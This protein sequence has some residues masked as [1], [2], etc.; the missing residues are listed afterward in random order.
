[1]KRFLLPA[2]ILVTGIA[3]AITLLQP[4]EP[5]PLTPLNFPVGNPYDKEW[6]Q[7]DSLTNLGLP[8][9]ALEI[10]E[11]IYAKALKEKNDAQIIKAL[12]YKTGSVYS[13]E[14]DAQIKSVVELENELSNIKYPAQPVLQSIIASVYWRY[15]QT[16]RWQIQNRTE[17]SGFVPDDVRTW[18]A[19]KFVNKTA[20]LYFESLQNADSLKRT[21]LGIFDSILVK[22]EASKNFRPTLYDFLAHRALEFFMNSESGLTKP[23]YQFTIQDAAYFADAEKFAAMKIESKDSISFE[24][25]ALKLLQDLLAFHLSQ[26]NTLP[27][28]DNDLTRLRFAHQHSVNEL[29]DSLYLAALKSLEAKHQADT[30]SARVGY[31]IA[32]QLFEQ[33]GKYNYESAKQYRWLKKA[34]YEKCEEVIKRHPNTIGANNCDALKEQ[35]LQKSLNLTVEE[36][37]IP[38]SPF[39]GLLHYQNLKEVWMRAV[40]LTIEEQ[41]NFE[42]IEWENRVEFLTGKQPA[43]EWSLALLAQTDFNNHQTEIKIPALELGKYYVLVSSTKDFSQAEGGIA[44]AGVAVSNLSYVNRRNSDNSLDFYVTD[45]TTG[46]PLAGVDVQTYTQRYNYESRKHDFQKAGN[47]KT[48]K[49]GYFRIP[50]AD[51]YETVRL[52]LSYKDDFLFE[53]NTFYTYRTPEQQKEKWNTKTFFFLDRAIYRPGQTVY[54]KGLVLQSNGE[55]NE[56]RKSYSAT[57]ELKDVNYQKVAEV[58]VTTNEFGT[59]NGTFTLPQGLLNGNFTL[60]TESGSKYFRVEDYKRPKFEVTFKPVTGSFRLNDS[61]TVEG[62]AVSYS[63]A[64]LSDAQ[65]QYRVVREARF[66][67]WWGW[68]KSMY[69]TSPAMEIT[70]GVATSDANGNFKITFKAIPDPTILKSTNPVFNYTVFADVTDINGETQ[71]SEASASVGYQALQA[72]INVEE[73]VFTN[74]PDTLRIAVKNLNGQPENAKGIITIS[75]LKEPE[76]LLRERLWEKADTFMLS[77]EEYR[78]T[79][80]LDV[81]GDEDRFET[82]EK[83]SKAL[84]AAFDTETSKD[85]A[86]TGLADWKPGKY[87]AELLTK[88]KFGTEVKEKKF[89]TVYNPSSKA[90]PHKTLSWFHAVKDNGEPGETAKFLIGSSA[91]DVKVLYE[92]FSKNSVVCK[93]WIELSNEVK[94]IE[95]PIEESY[96]GNFAVSLVFTKHGRSFSNFNIVT[97]PFTN[98]ELKIET[99]TFRDKLTPGQKEEWRVKITGAKGE[100]VA[101]EML[102]GMYDAS[103]DAFVPNNW[104]FSIYNSYYYYEKNWQKFTFG[105][106]NAQLFTDAWNKNAFEFKE[107]QYD[108]LNWFLLDYFEGT[109]TYGWG[110]DVRYRNEV[111]AAADMAVMQELQAV[112]VTTGKKNSKKGDVAFA[113]AFD[114]GE[115]EILKEKSGGEDKEQANTEV[116][117]VSP[118]KNLQET[119]FFFPDL[120]TD[121]EGNIIF[122]FTAPEALTRW[123]F[124]SFAHTQDLKLGFLT[125][126]TVTQKELMVMPNPPRFFRENDKITFSSK[127]S[128]VS[129]KDLSGKAQLLLFDALTMKPVDAAFGNASNEKSFTVKQ[130]G[131]TAVSWELKIPEGISAILYRVLAS[132]ENFSDGEENALPVLTNSMLVTETLPLNVRAGQTKQF[133][134]EKLI[135]NKSTTLRNQKLTLEFTSNPAWYAIQALPYMMEYPYDC[136]EQTFNRYYANQIATGIANS[137]P[138]IK[139]VFETWKNVNKE[140]LVSNLEKN[141]ELKSLLLEET[142]WVLDAQDETERKKRIALLFDINKMASEKQ[143]ALK[144]LAEAQTPNGGWA[145]FKGMP[146]NRYITQY[147]VTGIGRLSNMQ[148]LN[149]KEEQEVQ[150]MLQ[151]AVQYL[152]NRIL[153]DYNELKKRK[154]KLEDDNLGYEHVQYLYARTMFQNIPFGQEQ[155]E[156]FKYYIG[157]AEKYWLTRN[158]YSQ[159]MIAL[160]LQRNGKKESALKITRSLKET[161]LSS[162]EM[163]MYWRDNDGGYYWYEAPVETQALLVEAFKVVANDKQAVDEL[164]IWLLKQKQTQDWGNT[165]ATADACYALLL[166]GTQWLDDSKLADITVGETKIEPAQR[167]ASVEAGTG[168]FK[169]SWDKTEIKPAMGNISVSKTGTGIGWGAMYWQYFEQLDKITPAE[170]PL[171]LKKQLFLQTN[172]ET[173]PVIT[174]ITDKTELNVGDLIKVRI[175]LRVDRTMEFVHMKDMRAAGFEPVNVL[176]GYR[177]Q[178]GLGYYETTRDA[179]TNFFFDWLP[180]GTYVFEYALRVSQKGDFSNGVTTIQCMYAPEFASHSEGVR[181]A[182]R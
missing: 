28:V 173:G 170:T 123:K 131:N 39:R 171:K 163:G 77:K 83:E 101:A 137:N 178:G 24:F 120:K 88:D 38:D 15:Y 115:S 76:H 17:T 157:Q 147:I 155:N 86:L 96:R 146:D 166:E 156:A 20:E 138:R 5:K 135:S 11:K 164:R 33:G 85:V 59:F 75:K 34:A 165:K 71:S 172:S 119:A 49:D 21:S 150:D 13:F 27:L 12:I 2:L 141:Q 42:S 99:T 108:R 1:M 47:Y 50:S 14:E 175:E 41:K 89:F 111:F 122:S 54:F 180:K 149:L 73:V 46:K 102:A 7:V 67:F 179:A 112:T 177:W 107:Q 127:I 145:W 18:D 167:G 56:I 66:P 160:A 4:D 128:N 65:V 25:H 84:D 169:T 82:W 152:D 63:G 133:K 31:A 105:V 159:G 109:F 142:P 36:V 23:A 125:K 22:G 78:K 26:K 162:E 134:F 95:I 69:P 57:I 37:N 106:S 29:N 113:P 140:A 80:P 110:G 32:Q 3:V 104:N 94:T 64:N 129:E 153:D 10:I 45:R 6:K 124:M 144:K 9:S 61:V 51:K 81:Y 48:D 70:N 16:Q 143:S 136:A 114:G 52:E 103:L 98:K 60:W 74:T 43:Q 90:V 35:I 91:K 151:R 72:E 93:Q 181:V 130:G 30:I 148:V 19:A 182:V 79:F 62:S 118:R 126:E 100:Q 8:Q 174:P 58:K 116:S 168:Y 92:V 68:Y 161:S 132:A 117:K 55:A 154:V 139:Q 158:K 87:V 97:V 176:S 53:E 121:A 40:K 44:Y